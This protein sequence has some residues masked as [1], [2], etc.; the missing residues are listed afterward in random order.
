MEAA[1]VTPYL[2]GVRVLDFTQYLAGPA[3]TRLMAELGADV[4]KVELPPYGDAARSFAPRVNR[5]SAFF[6]QQNRGK[7]SL[8]VD[9]N[10]EDGLA[11]VKNLASKVDVVV[12]NFSPG[13]MARK[14]L[15]YESLSALNPGLVMASVSG[16]GQTGPL[17]KRSMFDFLAQ[18]YSGLMHMTGDPDGPPTFAGIGLADTNAGVHAF[19]AIGHALFRKERTGQGSYIDISMVESLIHMHESAVHMPSLDPTYEAQRQGRHYQLVSPGGTFKGPEGWIVLLCTVNQIANLWQA[20]GRPELADD[21]RFATND[22][23]MENRDELTEI[24]EQWMAGFESDAQLLDTLAEFRVPATAVLSPAELGDQEHL[25][26]RGAIREVHDDAI[27][28]LT[29]P[30][31]PIHYSPAPPPPELRAPKLGEHNDEIL[32]EFGLS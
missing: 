26:A 19:A 7:R 15:D 4:I 6:V 12:E 21:K 10:T 11:I 2:D 17:A 18:A 31:F 32:N 20:L 3:C 1:E 9:I 30:G 27:G 24:I 29:I 13:V 5:Q 22:G 23:R 16:Y 25:R 14:G 8:C 28:E